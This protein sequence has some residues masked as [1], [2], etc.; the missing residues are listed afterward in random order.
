M[1]G[2]RSRRCPR[3]GKVT[4]SGRFPAR[5]GGRGVAIIFVRS[6]ACRGEYR[7]KRKRRFQWKNW[8]STQKKYCW[9]WLGYFAAKSDEGG[10]HGMG[11]A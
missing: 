11:H 5:G 3:S 2:R 6:G 8:C 9:K 4:H 7:W 10:V 1:T